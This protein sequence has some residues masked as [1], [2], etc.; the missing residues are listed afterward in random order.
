MRKKIYFKLPKNQKKNNY[1]HNL[2]CIVQTEKSF[3]LN[4]VFFE[5]LASA[6]KKLAARANKS[7]HWYSSIQHVQGQTSRFKL[8]VF[9]FWQKKKRI[10]Y[11]CF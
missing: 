10:F 4:Y 1:V 11:S 6:L 9:E 7:V 2:R 5:F 3:D 8:N